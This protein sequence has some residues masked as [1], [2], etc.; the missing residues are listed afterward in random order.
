MDAEEPQLTPDQIAQ[1][2]TA[3]AT[4][5]RLCEIG[6][7]EN[8]LGFAR[9]FQ[10]LA[11]ARLQMIALSE[12]RV[13]ERR[14]DIN[15]M[16]SGLAKF[17]EY[18]QAVGRSYSDYNIARTYLSI[19]EGARKR[20][21]LIEALLNYREEL[22]T[23]RDL[24]ARTGA[25][26]E[27]PVRSRL[28]SWTDLG[29]SLD[30]TGRHIEALEAYDHALELNPRFGM[31]L[32][33]RGMTLLARAARLPDFSHPVLCEAVA[34]LDA[35]LAEP[36][37]IAAH[38]DANA[39]NIFKRERARVQGTPTHEHDPIELPEP[40]LEW[41]RAKELLLHPSPRCITPQTKLLD[42]VRFGH[43][44]IGI[45]DES[46]ARLR[47]L[48][49]ALNALLQDYISARYLG[50]QTAE[51]GSDL[52]HGVD[53]LNQHAGFADT[54]SYARWG[55]ATGLALVALAAANNLLDKVAGVTHLYL[56][57]GRDR[58]Y[59][60]EF[61]LKPA[62]KKTPRDVDDVIEEELKA[63]NRGLLALCDLACELERPSALKTVKG[64]RHAVTHRAIA[65]HDILRDDAPK[66][67]VERISAEELRE[68]IL[69]QLRRGKAA[70]TYLVD[71]IAEHEHRLHP[72]RDL[73][74]LP[75]IAALTED[76][77][78]G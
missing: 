75:Y 56:Q 5:V 73:P 20:F 52:R 57:T 7:G 19:W 31:A 28:T 29:N 55:T 70:L 50:W 34:A 74:S 33:N 63:G 78:H 66:D 37:S 26:R 9:R 35:A 42:A 51:P 22:F 6:D 58:V 54:L 47:T 1:I 21:G 8:A 65:V 17:E 44:T 2:H 62:K 18:D 77:D 32:G 67:W 64:R 36:E 23:A 25:D 12:A 30:N 39:L 76:P 11:M 46:Q 68:G 45:D 49:D 15:L 24:Y 13:G 60:F 53:V 10:G 59:F 69:D 72:K 41:C 4:L 43:L 48:Q 16:R 3:Q 14:G 27:Q 40:H 71:L 61:W 38:G